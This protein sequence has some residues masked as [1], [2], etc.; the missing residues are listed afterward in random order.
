MHSAD[1]SKN[2]AGK[3]RRTSAHDGGGVYGPPAIGVGRPEP[4]GLT[5]GSAVVDGSPEPDGRS[6]GRRLT[7]DMEGSEV[8][9]GAN[10]LEA[11]TRHVS[12]GHLAPQQIHQQ[13]GDQRTMHDQAGIA[14]HLRHI[15]AVVMD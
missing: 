12:V 3:Q 15:L 11:E 9:R 1:Y 4:A 5:G 7:A 10:G 6:V 14:F 8:E 13:G 2:S